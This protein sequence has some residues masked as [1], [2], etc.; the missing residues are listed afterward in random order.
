MLPLP[1][2]PTLLTLGAFLMG[3]HFSFGQSVG[4]VI[5]EFV[6]DNTELEDEDLDTPDWIELFND[7]DTPINLSGYFLTNDPLDRTLWIMPAIILQPSAH[8]LVFA[9][10]K[11]RPHTST[12]PHT[13]FRLPK[14]GGYLAL[15]APDGNTLVSEIT[16]PP[17]AEDVSFAELGYL[18]TPTPGV[19]N[20]G[21]Q[22]AAPPA[23]SVSFSRPGGLITE[24]VSLSIAP[25]LSPTAVVHYTLDDSVPDENSQVY[26]TP[27]SISSTTTVRARVFD[28]DHLPSP[29]SS[30]TFLQLAADVAGFTSALP[31]VIADSNGFNIDAE[32]DPLQPRPLRPVYA[33]T[34]DTDPVDGFARMSGA[35][36]YNGRGGMHVR[37]NSS[38]G[39]PKRQYAWELWNN[40]DEDS[41]SSI[42]GMPSE[43]DWI[44]HAPYSDKTLMRNQLVYNKA[45]AIHG[46]GGGMR[47][48]YVEVFFNQGGEPVTMADYQG[49]YLVMETIKRDASRIDIEKLNDFM[50][51]PAQISGGYIFKKDK[52][53]YSRPWN[54]ATE[55]IA[56]DLHVPDPLNDAQ[57]SW[58]TNHVNAFEAALHGPA[59]DDPQTGYASFIDVESF[60]DSHLFVEIFKDVDGF[61]LSHYFTKSRFGKI[62]ALPVWDY[63][64]SLGNANYLDAENP[65][66]W[67]HE[68]MIR[69]NYYWYP[70]LFDDAE[71]GLAYWDRFWALR[72]TS[73]AE[74]ALFAALDGFDA[75]L[76]APN[77]SGQSAVTRNFNRWPIL[78]TYVWPNAAGYATRTT[79][80]SEIDWMKDWMQERM[81]WI[82][83]QSRGTDGPASPP[84]FSDDGGNVAAGFAL[85]MTHS[86][87][88]GGSG[89]YYTMDG[90]DP[91]IPGTIQGTQTVLVDQDASCD[92]FVPTGSNGGN[93]LTVAQW[94]GAAEPP[95]A[96]SWTSGMQGV[97]YETAGGTL[98]AEINFDIKTEMLGVNPSCYL[99]FSFNI[100]TQAEIDSLSTLTLRVKYD[101]SFAAFIN[102]D[103]VAND[104]SRTP[105]P[106]AW[107]SSAIGFRSDSLAIQWTDF[108]I[109]GHIGKLQPGGNTL[110]IQMLD[111][112]A[113]GNDALCRVE[114]VGASGAGN[115]LSPTANLYQEAL[116]LSEST[117]LRARVFDGTQWSPLTSAS[118]I[119][120]SIPAS[121]AN[122][123]VSE[124]DYR[125]ATPSAGRDRLRIH[126]P[127]RIRVH[128]TH[129]HPSDREH[130]SHRRHVQRWH[131][132]HFRPDAQS[133][134]AGTGTWW[135]SRI[136]GKP[137]RLCDATS[138]RPGRGN[139]HRIPEQ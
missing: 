71:F 126:F 16:Y 77:A 139:I 36:D 81:A 63:N 69:Q 73:L 47:S 89:I 15:V 67:R 92:V 79:H 131:R 134:L 96:A 12:P 17:Q 18:E 116:V 23:E 41:A 4:P 43:S 56:F 78:G 113:G 57:Y 133:R 37:G 104:P 120:D 132:V 32:N 122:L 86:N 108:D 70:R 88:W 20:E 59:F 130:R 25:P 136:G 51:D 2:T 39:F 127:G 62:R 7:Q 26:S 121:A 9:S 124:L 82:E 84:A 21:R 118:F 99:R 85:S 101:D 110:G 11:D 52:P 93:S 38:A 42:L 22:A 53:P 44:L 91:R 66:G 60:I 58:L 3:C 10:G 117:E 29:T 27:F 30:R 24:T 28:T 94:A 34:I 137:G 112:G 90:S 107:N 111:F 135:P 75:E 100:A 40:E 31:I 87:S 33:V 72:R 48:R 123:V 49:V 138:R 46:N 103:F 128:R 50:T 102:G 97:G 106:L 45:R 114:L 5:S 129:E 98:A 80:Q 65:L 55:G 125:P 68:S 119:V 6:A 115:T 13:N 35:T 83:A 74:G 105:N 64:L 19:A 14:E 8:A 76:D 95:N 109:T 61:R 1:S 54:T